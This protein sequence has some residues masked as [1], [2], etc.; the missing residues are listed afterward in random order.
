MNV[1]A[2]T[3]PIFKNHDCKGHSECHDRL[4]SV[5]EALPSGIPIYEPVPATRAQ[6]ERVHVPGY[7]TWLERQCRKHV[8]FCSLDE[9]MCTGGYFENNQLVPGYLD[10]NTYINPCS[11]EVATYAAGSA[12][13]AAERALSDERCFALIR[14]PGHH[15]EADK[16]MGFCLLNNAAVAAAETLKA[17]DRVAII[18]WDAHHGNGTQS[19]FYADNR[20]LYC[21]IHQKDFFPHTGFL[22]ETGSGDGEGFNINA[23]L[24]RNSGIADYEHVFKEIF[25]PAL[26]RYK[27][28][29]LLIS[30]GQDIL[31]DDPQ[32]SMKLEPADFGLLTHITLE[33]ADCPTALV[34]EG[35]YGP[36]HGAAVNS[37]FSVLKGDV[38]KG[39]TGGM[40]GRDAIETVAR[41]K[42]L[43]RLPG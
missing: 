20:V 8:D 9:Y 43:H 34:L 33:A 17:V 42:K 25:D 23:P 22:E 28:D 18:D 16:A 7:L 4:L 38:P 19:I 32:A 40:P 27:P 12:V 15:A 5:L 3:G 39:N 11:Y 26:R 31:S 21:S 37:I 35:G 14:P 41:L 1:S 24:Q 6:L 13:A 2:I 29:L 36:S 30:A 10:P